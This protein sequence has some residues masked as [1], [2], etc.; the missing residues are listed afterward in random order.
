[1]H[2]IGEHDYKGFHIAG[3]RLPRTG[4]RYDYRFH[5]DRDRELQFTVV[6]RITGAKVTAVSKEKHLEEG[7]ALSEVLQECA[8]QVEVIIDAGT[9][10]VG[11]EVLVCLASFATWTEPVTD[12]GSKP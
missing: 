7:A 9:Y 6:C 5:V 10:K 1:M 2:K 4:D 8:A 11:D 3:Y 12:E